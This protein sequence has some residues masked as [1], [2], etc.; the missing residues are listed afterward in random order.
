[1]NPDEHGTGLKLNISEDGNS[2]NFDLAMSV[3][4]YFRLSE[5]RGKVEGAQDISGVRGLLS[6]TF[7]F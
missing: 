1:M 6:T 2:L 3:A 7:Y 5:P 4:P